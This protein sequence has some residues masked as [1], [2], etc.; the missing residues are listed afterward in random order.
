[1]SEFTIPFTLPAG[2]RN[3][4]HS[5]IVNLFLNEQAG[6]GTGD[7][8]THYRYNV[9][10]WQ[11]YIIYLKRP[12]RLNKGFDFQ[13]NV[14]GLSF[15]RSGRAY[16]Y[17]THDDICCLLNTAKRDFPNEYPTVMRSISDIYNCVDLPLPSM[18]V[19]ITDTNGVRHPV[20]P[21]LLTIKWLFMEQDYAYRNYSGRAKFYNEIAKRGL[22]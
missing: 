1:M 11:R 10:F 7:L 6:T 3:I 12:T 18:N 2:D 17:P 5:A 9:E 8:A 22:V 4:K 15:I 13:V 14:D 16:T 21:V 20:Q 19:H